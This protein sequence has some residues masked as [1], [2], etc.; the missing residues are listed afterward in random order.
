MKLKRIFSFMLCTVMLL[1][2][3][4]GCGGNAGKEPTEQHVPE[5][6]I[7]LDDELQRA[8]DAGLLPKEWLVDMDEPVTIAAFNGLLTKIVEMY[9][10]AL[11]SEWENIASKALKA[12]DTAQRDDAILSIFEAAIIMGIDTAPENSTGSSWEEHSPAEDWWE[13]RSDDY[14]YFPNWNM[15]Y[16]DGDD[17]D[18]NIQMHSAWYAEK[19][20]SLV[21][22]KH[23][24]EPT[25]KWTFGFDQPVTK[26][27]AVRALV[28]FTESSLA[29]IY[30]SGRDGTEKERVI[31]IEDQAVYAGLSQA[32]I[33]AIRNTAKERKQTILNSPSTIVNA[34]EYVMGESYCG[35]AYY[36]S[37][38]GNDGNTGRSPEK[39]FATMK[40]FDHIELEYGDA[41]FF[42]RGSLWRATE[43]HWKIRE[44]EGITVSAYG[45]G[46]KPAF[47]GSS[48]NGTGAEKWELYHSDESG[49]K[50]WKFYREMT[51]V[52][53]I[54]LNENEIV[55]R[56]VAYWD[57]NSYFQINDRLNDL[58]GNAYEVEKYLPD[59][60]CFPAIQYPDRVLENHTQLFSEW[61][62]HGNQIYYKGPL[63]FRCDTGNP[64]ELY[65]DIEF[66]QPMAF[67]DGMSDDQTYDNLCVRYS[68]KNF[69]TGNDGIKEACHGVIQ[70]CEIG[71]MGGQVFS[72][73]SGV[74]DIDE[75]WQ[76]NYGL[77][78][79]NCGALAINGSGYTVRNNYVHD[80]YQEGISLETF[81]ECGSMTD[82]VVAGN[83]VERATQGILIC[84]WDT[85]VNENHI[86]K[87]IL[88]EDNIVLDSGVNNFFSADWENDYC[89]AL[90]IQGGPCAHEGMTIRNNMF[91]FATGALIMIDEHSE[92]YSKVF[93]GNT[94]AQF[95]GKDDEIPENGISIHQEVFM[96]L[97]AKNVERLLG[98]ET[99]TVY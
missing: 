29:I 54:V 44:T 78:G 86:F 93:E 48:E 53:S 72:Y 91:A 32:E 14:D 37:N 5:N 74:G 80:A 92:A 24:F 65:K 94:Y 33:T 2:L 20:I 84:N 89:N 56:D 79:R 10:S 36:V 85:V 3:L 22:Q 47:Y 69:T 88:V 87:N 59:M 62:A 9:D 40:P 17:E 35:T 13:G 30:G 4:T 82:N 51:E 41:V 63:Y 11:V 83:L 77:F 19:H 96:P 25:E 66:I 73:A 50:I 61:D 7:V 70:N 8:S 28:R 38:R 58:T 99:G 76:L 6:T 21:S 39:P 81:P 16:H 26:E 55:R 27:E 45:E 42:E 46:P 43:L 97:T 71:W 23:M 18:Y 98:D 15:I 64:G 67:C 1:S 34:D 31:G 49:K 60:W 75:R 12:K 90:V 95:A 52:A 57:G 68:S